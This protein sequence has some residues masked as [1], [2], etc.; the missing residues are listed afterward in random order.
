MRVGMGELHV[1]AEQG[2][3]AA[4]Q[5]DEEEGRGDL[6]GFLVDKCVDH[7]EGREAQGTGGGDVEDSA[8]SSWEREG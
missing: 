3:V 4:A 6:N 8:E 7:G 1:E 2:D 5:E